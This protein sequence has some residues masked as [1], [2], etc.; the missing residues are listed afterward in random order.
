MVR[1]Y[2]TRLGLTQAE[3]GAVAGVTRGYVAA[4]ESG[5]ANPSLDV[6]E[7]IADALG[8]IVD[9]AYRAPSVHGDRDQVDALHARCLGQAERRL[10]SIG[11]ATAREVEIVHARSHGWIDLLAFDPGTRILIVIEVKT[12]LDDL[13]AIERQL[14][15][16]ERSAL[17]AARRMG[18]APERSMPWLLVLATA[19]ADRFVRDNKQT[20]EVNFPARARQMLAVAGGRPPIG[21]LSRGIALIDP[22]S[23]RSEWLVRST[24]DGRRS[25]APYLDLQHARIAM[26][27]A[28]SSR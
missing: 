16:Y 10:R 25:P 9:P 15:W 27:L 13:G 5:R 28:G 14:G 23:H 26:G 4:V 2:R 12:W 21:P 22:A 6:V 11:I 7:R 24:V 19:A 20:L 17:E 1:T 3:V 8:L 18:W